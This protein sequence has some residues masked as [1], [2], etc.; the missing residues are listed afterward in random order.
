VG[1]DPP[2]PESTLLLPE[3]YNETM[4]GYMDYM[5]GLAENLPR[6]MYCHG[7]GREAILRVAE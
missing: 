3:E 6:V 2:V 5:E 4:R 1:Q 7:A